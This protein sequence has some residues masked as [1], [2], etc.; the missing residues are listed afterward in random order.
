MKNN[1]TQTQ[2]KSTK[3]KINNKQKITKYNVKLI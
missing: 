2:K 1:P 3:F